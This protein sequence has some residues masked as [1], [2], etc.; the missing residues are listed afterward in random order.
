M[1]PNRASVSVARRCVSS[2]RDTSHSTPSACAPCPSISLT[3][4]FGS[5]M[6]ATTTRAPSAATPR[7]YVRP[8][9]FAPPVMMTTLSFSLMMLSFPES[10]RRRVL[11]SAGQELVPLVGVV[12]LVL[13]LG[14]PHEDPGV[15][16]L[17]GS[18]VP[19]LAAVA[20]ADLLRRHVLGVGVDGRVVADLGLLGA[21]EALEPEVDPLA[22]PVEHPSVLVVTM[23]EL[24][25]C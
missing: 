8:M 22:G 10:R 1:R 15:A 18:P 11:A 2:S 7:Q 5:A 14:V 23:R 20:L 3:M 9:P 17:D 25:F 19:P 21:R 4:G 12:L 6:S 24:R 16:P 13:G